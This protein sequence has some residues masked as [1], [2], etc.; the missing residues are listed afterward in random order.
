MLKLTD[1]KNSMQALFSINPKT[2]RCL[3]ESWH[4]T[5]YNQCVALKTCC[6]LPFRNTHKWAHSKW[7]NPTPLLQKWKSRSNK[8]LWSKTRVNKTNQVSLLQVFCIYNVQYNQISPV[9]TK[10]KPAAFLNYIFPITTYCCWVFC[11]RL[12]IKH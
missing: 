6:E 8:C 5:S 10:V 7:L 1:G 12:F 4:Y 11:I 3:S 9:R 2:K